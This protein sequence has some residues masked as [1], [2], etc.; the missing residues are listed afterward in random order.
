MK[1]ILLVCF[2]FFF[3]ATMAA[4]EEGQSSSKK[5]RWSHQ[6]S[7]S[8]N[9][10]ELLDKAVERA[11][12]ESQATIEKEREE[13]AIELETAEY[14]LTMY[15]ELRKEQTFLPR[16]NPYFSLGK[17]ENDQIYWQSTPFTL[18]TSELCFV[19]VISCS[20]EV[21]EGSLSYLECTEGENEKVSNFHFSEYPKMR[22]VPEVPESLQSMKIPESSFEL[23]SD[24]CDLEKRE[25]ENQ[26]RQ[27]LDV[28]LKDFERQVAELPKPGEETP[29]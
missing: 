22:P 8:G 25:K 11:S 23:E 12:A 27:A 1:T 2:F 17:I 24:F 14:P 4:A 15:S 6:K 19:R 13:L 18:P 10:R 16:E 20:K 28:Y 9:W 7:E 21:S 3:G 26:W 5:G 29:E